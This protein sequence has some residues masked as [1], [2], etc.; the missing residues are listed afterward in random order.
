MI[1]NI[2]FFCLGYILCA[3]RVQNTFNLKKPDKVLKW[4]PDVFGWRPVP[5]GTSID[6]DET[7]LFAF[8]MTKS[9]DR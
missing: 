8:E 4:D 1:E 7:V 2:L 5:D 3:L 6:P 9:D